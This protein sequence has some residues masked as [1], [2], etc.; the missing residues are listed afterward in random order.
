MTKNENCFDNIKEYV[1]VRHSTCKNVCVNPHIHNFYEIHYNISG[2]KGYMAN[3]VFYKCS[4]RDLIIIPRLVPHKV[5]VGYEAPDY[6]RCIINIDRNLLSVLGVV[7]TG[8]QSISDIITGTGDEVRKTNLTAK[9]HQEFI[10]LID[11]YTKQNTPEEMLGIFTKILSFLRLCFENLQTPQFMDEKDISHTDRLVMIIEKDLRQSVSE[12][13]EKAYCSK[14][15]LNRVFKADMGVTVKTYLIQRRLAEAQKYLCMG[16]NVK[17]AC[18]LS[19]FKNYSNFLRTFKN[20]IGCSPGEFIR[21]EW[22]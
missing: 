8:E 4:K 2:A 12:I 5:M 20:H 6:E 9:E 22:A 21:K 14:E 13:A 7:D 16:K 11:L 15:H 19:G 1:F 10:A 18:V 3:G 17:E